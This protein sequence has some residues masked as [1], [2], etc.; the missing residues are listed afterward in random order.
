M[1]SQG[2]VT[3]PKFNNLSAKGAPPN[4]WPLMGL[5]FVFQR[6][7]GDKPAEMKPETKNQ[8]ESK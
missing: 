8:D 4:K 6:S 5:D 1:G 2:E 3:R 7:M